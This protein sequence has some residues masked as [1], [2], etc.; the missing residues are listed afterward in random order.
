MRNA[1]DDDTR[2]DQAELPYLSQLT[3]THRNRLRRQAI[4]YKLRS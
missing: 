4:S 2:I 3:G 1:L